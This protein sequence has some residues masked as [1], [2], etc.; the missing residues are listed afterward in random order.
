MRRYTIGEPRGLSLRKNQ[1]G[2]APPLAYSLPANRHGNCPKNRLV[3]VGE[4]VGVRGREAPRNSRPL[5]PVLSP[6]GSRAAE[7]VPHFDRGGEGD[8]IVTRSLILTPMG[9]APPLARPFAPKR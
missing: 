4:R 2:Q 3:L 6:A 7:S 5:S 8:R 9:Q 1:R